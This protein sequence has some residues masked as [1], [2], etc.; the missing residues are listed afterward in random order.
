VELHED[1]RGVFAQGAA[2]QGEALLHDRIELTGNATFLLGERSADLVDVAGKRASLAQL[3]A[4]LIGIPGVQ[5]GV[6]L[7]GEGRGTVDR[8]AAVVVAPD[9]SRQKLLL[10]LRQRIDP[11]FLPRPLV[12]VESL[13]RNALGK[14]PRDVLLRLVRGEA[15]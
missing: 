13:P 4:L 14:L 15:A 6:F 3:N 12:F 5:D 10:A 9:L 11:A 1:A 8:L 7:M 2:V